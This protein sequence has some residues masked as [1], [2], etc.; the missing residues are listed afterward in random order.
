MSCR[1]VV[2]GAGGRMGRLVALRAAADPAFHLVGLIDRPGHA[3][4][5]TRLDGLGEAAPAISD[6]LRGALARG[7]DV[8]VEFALA[9]ASAGTADAAAAAGVACLIGTTGHDDAARAAFDRAAAHIPLLVAANM[10][11][12]ITALLSQLG[13]LARALDG[14]DVAIVEAHHAAKRD[15]PS[16]TALALGRALPDPAAV[17]YSSIRAGSLPGT[18]TVLFAGTGE[19]VEVTHRAE[20]RECFAAGAL[21]AAL[22]LRGRP[23]GCYTMQDV[24]SSPTVPAEA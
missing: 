18:H 23:A 8:V 10:S 12:G 15:A 20:S 21:R 3:S 6:D 16:G 7:A 9:P 2:V 22:W 11:I 13:G 19:H 5:G 1:L 24:L 17:R 4:L 14:F